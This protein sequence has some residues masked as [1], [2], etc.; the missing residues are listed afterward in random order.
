MK[1]K[2]TN[3]YIS[4]S[5]VMFV[6]MPVDGMVTHDYAQGFADAI[7]AVLAI[8]PTHEQHVQ[9]VGDLI[10]RA[11][12]FNALANVKTL[13]EAFVAIQNA[14]EVDAVSREEYANDKAI[15]MRRVIE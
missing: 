3:E 8:P 14:P 11:A 10:S 2:I 12:L 5:D 7:D 4:K 6:S 13:E 15:W 1:K 9:R